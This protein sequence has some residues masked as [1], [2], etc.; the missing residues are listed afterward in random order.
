MKVNFNCSKRGIVLEAKNKKFSMDFPERIWQTY[1]DKDF[2]LDNYA[3][4]S[5]ICMP[6]IA[7]I[8]KVEYNTSLPLFKKQFSNMILGDIPCST[9]DYARGTKETI[10]QF[11][12]T[13]YIFSSNQAKMPNETLGNHR[14]SGAPKTPENQG[15]SVS[16]KSGGFSRTRKFSSEIN[17]DEKAIIPLSCGKDSLLTLGVAREIGLKPIGIYIDD[18]VSPSENKIKIEMLKQIE[19]NEK[20]KC[21]VVINSLEKFNDFE[22]WKKAETCLGYGHMV[23]SFCFAS[24]PFLEFY[25]AK[26]VVLGNQQDLEW[27]IKNKEG[28]V[29]YPSFDQT[30]KWQTEQ[31]KMIKRATN[32]AA[33]ITSII[34]P[35]TDLGIMHV[36]FSR[37][38]ELAKHIVSCDSLDASNEKRWCAD[39]SG[40]ATY[41]LF[42]LAVGVNP[43]TVGLS[44]MLEKKHE[45]FYRLFDGK[46]TEFYDDSKNARG[47]QLLAFYMAMKNGAKGY[48]V[49]KFKREF[50]K[51]A[52]SREDE[53]RKFFFSLHP[54]DIPKEIKSDVLSIYREELKR[55]R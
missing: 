32:N 24:L 36:L 49:D 33:E 39:C 44:P 55:I 3:L 23:T 37:Y 41:S 29:I 11:K 50:L 26:Y 53:L 14:I 54:A 31:N 52:V 17:S 12:K 38:K 21:H 2:F 46:K 8:K 42:M 22:T 20:I 4:L 40:C 25:N 7:G 15:F 19:K 6:L 47:K 10:E 51:E 16:R 13:K 43:K 45:K 1:R 35:L 5:T 34:R 18:T 28:F 48:L 30:S 9:E 27:G